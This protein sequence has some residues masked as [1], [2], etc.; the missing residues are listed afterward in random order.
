MLADYCLYAFF[1]CLIRQ[2]SLYTAPDAAFRVVDV[3]EKYEFTDSERA[4]LESMEEPFAIYQF[5]DKH[6]VTSILSNG[7]CK[8][9]GYDDRA[10]AYYD[11]D[12]NMY[13]NT[14]P[15]DVSRIANAAI[16]FAVE[17]GEYDVLYRSRREGEEKYHIIHAHGEH[18]FT[19]DGFRLAHV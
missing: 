1:L 16:K 7:F 5:I 10:R 6:V 14:H 9:F 4:L 11:M 17:G 19:D 8:L 18:S 3:M 15:D 2:V 13:K 12:N